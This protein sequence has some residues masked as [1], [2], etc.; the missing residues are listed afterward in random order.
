MK[1]ELEESSQF[2]ITCPQW[3]FNLVNFPRDL[4]LYQLIMEKYIP[5]IPLSDDERERVIQFV[6]SCDPL[7]KTKLCSTT[8]TGVMKLKLASVNKWIIKVNNLTLATHEKRIVIKNNI[9][10]LERVNIMNEDS[11]RSID[12]S[13][14]FTGI[15]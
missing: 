3:D 1:G 11:S 5:M 8:K 15:R 10:S 9:S 2:S 4:T 7:K 6:N 14:N 12:I 13:M